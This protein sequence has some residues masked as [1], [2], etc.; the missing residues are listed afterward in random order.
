MLYDKNLYDD[1]KK[2]YKKAIE[3]NPNSSGALNGLGN[4]SYQNSDFEMAIDFY[5]QAHELNTSSDIIVDNLAN[6]FDLIGEKYKAVEYYEKLVSLNE[7]DLQ[8]KY[9]LGEAY[10]TRAKRS[11]KDI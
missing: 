2:R 4:I 3:L 7:N 9:W 11:N 5:Q 6:V 1:S 8:S 10:R